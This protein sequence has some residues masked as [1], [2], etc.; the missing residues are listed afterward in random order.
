MEKFEAAFAVVP[1]EEEL[2]ALGVNR[3]RESKFA[4]DSECSFNYASEQI[5]IFL[6]ISTRNVPKTLVNVN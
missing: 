4:S 5:T 3:L 1:A 2:W 6:E